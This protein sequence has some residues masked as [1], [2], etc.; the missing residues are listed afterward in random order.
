M[1][2]A[3]HK[4]K[5]KHAAPPRGKPLQDK[6]P[7]KYR[8]Q[9][10]RRV[11][12][13]HG[14]QAHAKPTAKPAE[15]K[16]VEAKPVTTTPTEKP[17]PAPEAKPEPVGVRFAD[18]DLRPE[19]HAAIAAMGFATATPI[20]AETI[21]A[22]MDGQ[23]VI[24][25]AQTGTG[26]TAAF[27]VP[28][29][30]AAHEGRR[31][32]VLAPTRELAKQ[33]QKELQA[34]A[35]G[36]PVEI[37]CLIGGDPMKDQVRAMGRHP[38]ATIVGTPGRI[39]DHLGR[40][41]LDLRDIGMFVLDEADEMLSMGFADEL[42]T[43]VDALPAERQNVLFTAT[44]SPQIEK[45]AKKALTDPVTV[46]IGAGAA[47]DVRQGFAQVAGRDRLQAVQRILEV[48]APRSTILF[49]RTRARVDDLVQGLAALD[50]EALHGG[51]DQSRREQ[52][53]R[54]FREGHTSLLVATDVAARG[55]DV[56]TVDLVLHDE[57]PADAD[58]YIH[59]IG[60]TGRAGR[61]GISILF[62][63]PG[64]TNRLGSIRRVAG[65][66]E[67][68]AVPDEN[69]VEAA[70]GKRVVAQL[71]GE[72]PGDGARSALAAALAN[73]LE[74]EDIALRALHGLVA[75]P[76]VETPSEQRP[77]ALA[78]KVGKMDSVHPGA[79]V[80]VLTNAGGLRAEDV[81]R[82]DILEKMSVVEVPAKEVDRLC[83]ALGRVRLSNRPLLPRPADDWRFK[84]GPR[85]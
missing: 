76:P 1:S 74:L 22:L 44:L 29:V 79:I 16:P 43:I 81:G 30:E 11:Q 69:E 72:E 63:A 7:A 52:V 70:R 24:G 53:M 83:D 78:L 61:S 15:A 39:V 20:Q 58:T 71:L 68:Y 27:G 35:K 40:Q 10:Q 66:L 12:N 4:A 19:T 41:N 48:E 64:K 2:R 13:G 54:R 45:L 65:R 62:I 56:D 85:R 51:M 60:R 6:R 14:E 9:E 77:S 67:T 80:G 38:N 49:A 59:R 18:M 28:L 73:G 3:F 23:D 21:P 75:A 84:S 82:I 25:Q 50:A 42:E 32:L 34:I 5:G 55:L 57:P 36:S 31:G 37:V 47:P 17:A 33:V 26:K 8:L 46:R